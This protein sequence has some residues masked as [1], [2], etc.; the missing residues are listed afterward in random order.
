MNNLSNR[1][2]G[3]V[4]DIE[5]VIKAIENGEEMPWDMRDVDNWQSMLDVLEKIKE[6]ELQ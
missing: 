4:D 2:E 1:I 5:Q 6:R 3:L